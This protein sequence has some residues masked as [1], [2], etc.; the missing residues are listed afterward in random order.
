MGFSNFLLVKSAKKFI[1]A[2]NQS[3]KDLNSYCAGFFYRL[4][5]DSNC[6][7]TATVKVAKVQ[8]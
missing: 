3:E 4:I 6:H 1:S 2:K 5:F 8:F 7:S